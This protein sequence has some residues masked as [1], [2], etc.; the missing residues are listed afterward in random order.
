[1]PSTPSGCC[2]RRAASACSV[3]MFA[4]R[5]HHRHDRSAHRSSHS[6]WFALA[7]P[8]CEMSTW[9]D[10]R[11]RVADRLDR[12]SAGR[13]RGHH[14]GAD[15][16][17]RVSVAAAAPAH[18]GDRGVQPGAQR[19]QQ[20]RRIGHAH[21][22]RGHEHRR[23]APGWSSTSPRTA[24]HC[25]RLTTSGSIDPTTQHGLAVIEHEIELQAAMRRL[26]R[27][28]PVPR[29]RCIGRVAAAAAGRRGAHRHGG[30]HRDTE[31]IAE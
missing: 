13:R 9:T 21:A 20:R 6:G 23:A 3:A 26:Q 1:M 14:A 31:P 16:A 5:A 25:A 28:V 17:H 18:R 22:L 11:R 10:G 8:S 12:V 2:S 19:L 29:G 4:E 15:P 30:K 24:R 7:S 27:G